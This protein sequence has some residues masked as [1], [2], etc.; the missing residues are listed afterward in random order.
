MTDHGQIS[1]LL[2]ANIARVDQYVART[3]AQNNRIMLTSISASGISTL[4]AGL[5]SAVGEAAQ[6][7]V[8]GWRMACIVA[9]ALG[10]VA[11]I[12]AGVSQQRNLAEKVSTGKECLSRLKYLNTVMAMGTKPAA[13]VSQEYQDLVVRFPELID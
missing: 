3:R 11:T 10:F 13:E 5:T 6:I 9:A 1:E 2:T 8:A 4:V 12:T 7:G